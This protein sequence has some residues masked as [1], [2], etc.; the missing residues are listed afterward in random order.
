MSKKNTGLLIAL[1][2][3]AG[4]AAAG[5]S[6]YLKYKSF[7]EDVEKDFHEYEDEDEMEEEAEASSCDSSN[8]T[9]I[10]LNKSCECTEAC[11]CGE[12]C[13]CE[14]TCACEESCTCEESCACE[15]KEASEETTEACATATVKEETEGEAE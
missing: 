13:E 5:I 15:E 12:T 4:A 11:E 10:T 14:E 8:R 6:Y 1:G 2:A 7:N 3:I 9:Y